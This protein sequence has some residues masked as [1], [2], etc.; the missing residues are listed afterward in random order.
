MG[1]RGS[2]RLIEALDSAATQLARL[3]SPE[4][5]QLL[6]TAATAAAPRRTGFL[7][8]H[9]EVIVT[10]GRLQVTNTAPYAGYVHAKDPWLARTLEQ[11][12]ADVLTAYADAAADVVTDIR[13]A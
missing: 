12:T 6:D 8:D 11:H 10:A 9:H 1:V 2:G 3:E 13:G 7:A 4:A 5:G